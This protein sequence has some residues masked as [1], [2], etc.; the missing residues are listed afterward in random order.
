MRIWSI[1]LIK[2]DLKW[3]IHLSRSLYLYSLPLTRSLRCTCT[4]RSCGKVSKSHSSRGLSGTSKSVRWIPNSR[5]MLHSDT[6]LIIEIFNGRVSHLRAKYGKSPPKIL[7]I[8][9][10]RQQKFW[11]NVLIWSY[12]LGL[13]KTT[14]WDLCNDMYFIWVYCFGSILLKE[15]SNT[16]FGFFCCYFNIVQIYTN[17]EI[18]TFIY[19]FMKY[20]FKSNPCKTCNIK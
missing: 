10:P 20:L 11:L 9:T 3:C 15:V 18:K 2:S 13:M 8:F 14:R 17:D 4:M 7:S 16:L 12:Y 19:I 6:P 1:L 5:N